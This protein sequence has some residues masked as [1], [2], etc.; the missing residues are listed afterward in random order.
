MIIISDVV[1]A[2][3]NDYVN[4]LINEDITSQARAFEKKN[5]MIKG[6]H[7]NLGGIITHRLSPYE[8]LGSEERCLIY[9]YKDPKSKTQ[10]G[11]AYKRFDE[12]NVIVYYM[13]NLKLVKD[14]QL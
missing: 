2:L 8:E 10:W 13:R 11:F 3:I 1:Y 7:S 9:V 12:N 14:N 4:Y 6:I 5:L